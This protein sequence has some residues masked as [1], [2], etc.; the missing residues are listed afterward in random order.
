MTNF[1]EWCKNSGNGR[2][3]SFYCF[4]MDDIPEVPIVDEK[5]FVM[6][7]VLVVVI[8][9]LIIALAIWFTYKNKVLHEKKD[10]DGKDEAK[11]VTMKDLREGADKNG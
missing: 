1:G 2:Y 6:I 3:H 7:F 10:K 11:V 4:N 8:L 9:V 5:D